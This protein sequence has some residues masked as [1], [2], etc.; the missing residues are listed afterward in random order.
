VESNIHYPTD[1]ALLRYGLRW[2][3]RWIGRMR[4]ELGIRARMNTAELSWEKGHRV[5][6]EIVKLRGGRSRKEQKKNLPAAVETHRAG[7]GTFSGTPAEG[8]TNGSL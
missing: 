4:E 7:G 6:L 3:Y 2:M 8:A 1:S 5:Y